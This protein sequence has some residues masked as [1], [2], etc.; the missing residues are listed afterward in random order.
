MGAVPAGAGG[1][2]SHV[3]NQR[4]VE[5]PAPSLT[6]EQTAAIEQR[7]EESG[8]DNLLD[9]M[10]ADERLAWIRDQERRWLLGDDE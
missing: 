5:R 2:V 9:V 4:P 8:A 6:A 1:P 3:T 10:T 7:A